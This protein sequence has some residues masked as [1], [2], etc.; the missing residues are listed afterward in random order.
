ML[1]S[2]LSIVVVFLFNV[3][4][5]IWM[6]EAAALAFFGIAFLTKA[7]VYPW[8]FCDSPNEDKETDNA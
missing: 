1:L 5:G 6:V 4:A 3:Y 8:L 7:D 2:L